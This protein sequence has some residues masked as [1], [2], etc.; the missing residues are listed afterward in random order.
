MHDFVSV[1]IPAY[2]A[3]RYV[4]E[5]IESVLAQ[6]HAAREI[7][8]VDDGSTD[9]TRRVLERFGDAIRYQHQPN[10]G[11][12]RARNAGIK[13]ARGELIAF[14]DADDLWLPNKLELQLARLAERPKALLVHS[15]AYEL[16][17]EMG[18]R[19]LRTPEASDYSGECFD[20]LFHGN[21]I[22]FSTVLVRKAALD[23]VGGFDESIRQASV[24]DYD[25]LLRLAERYPLAV[26]ARPLVDYRVHAANASSDPWQMIAAE[27]G[28]LERALARDLNIQR[29]IGRRAVARRLHDLHLGLAYWARD[30]GQRS[31]ARRHF[32]RAA[33]ISGSL[34][35]GLLGCAAFFPNQWLG[36]LRTLR[37]AWQ[38]A[39][40]S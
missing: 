32:F 38:G 29:R 6:T 26:V 2:N 7:I 10:G 36:G 3:E 39:P 15:L 21:R 8:V 40:S 31:L 9:D 4:A 22:T 34:R 13:V 11:P 33:R 12:A 23:E 19:L 37:R 14:C 17:S 5:T 18:Q 24:E 30:N 1:V 20:R 16:N 28:V 25:L 35:S 27:L